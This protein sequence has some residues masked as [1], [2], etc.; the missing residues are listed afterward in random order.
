MWLATYELGRVVLDAGYSVSNF[1][2]LDGASVPV[3]EQHL[4]DYYDTEPSDKLLTEK[5]QERIDD[6]ATVIYCG[7]RVSAGGINDKHDYFDGVEIE[8]L[9][10]LAAMLKQDRMMS[11]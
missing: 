4:L 2:Y 9:P 5:I 11:T 1:H 7:L 10:D 6:G 3:E 8:L